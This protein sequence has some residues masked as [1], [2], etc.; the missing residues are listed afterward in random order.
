MSKKQ[1]HNWKMGGR[2]KLTFFQRGHAYGQH[3]HKRWSAAL[4]IRKIQIKTT[5]R[6]NLTPV[7][8]AIIKKTT[9][10]ECWWAREEKG[11][12]YMVGGNVNWCNHCKNTIKISPKTKNKLK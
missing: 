7:R 8:T 5:M 12:V 2:P 4:I 9:N 1:K 6:H 10:N 11:T 3:A